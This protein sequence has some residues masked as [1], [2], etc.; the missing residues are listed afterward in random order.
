MELMEFTQQA[1]WNLRF[2]CT[3]GVKER[4]IIGG[5]QIYEQ[6]LPLADRLYVTLIDHE[7][8]GDTYFPDYEDE[9]QLVSESE[10]NVAPEG[11]TYTY[12]VFERINKIK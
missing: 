1:V 5:A 6:A 12:C 2:F 4:M 11:Y 9:W 3:K 8:Q 10:P 7:F